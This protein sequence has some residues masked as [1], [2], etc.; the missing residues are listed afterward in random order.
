MTINVLV[1]VSKLFLWITYLWLTLSTGPCPVAV[2]SSA[3]YTSSSCE[4][5]C[6]GLLKVVRAVFSCDIL[7]PEWFRTS[8]AYPLQQQS[9]LLGMIPSSGDRFLLATSNRIGGK[10]PT[11]APASSC[12]DIHLFSKD[13]REPP[14]HLAPRANL[15]SM[16]EFGR[17]LGYQKFEIVSLA[18]RDAGE[19]NAAHA[20]KMDNVPDS[21]RNELQK[22]VSHLLVAFS[23]ELR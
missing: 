13:E 3:S 18:G 9:R 22:E 2:Q 16:F 21:T 1:W 5:H 11:V 23:T 17:A 7:Q 20:R 4:R 15:G 10:V 19:I 8:T 6:R 12:S 14:A